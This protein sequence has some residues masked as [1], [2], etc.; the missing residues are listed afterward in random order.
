VGRYSAVSVAV[1][2]SQLQ[3]TVA[4]KVTDWLSVG[5]GAALTMGYGSDKLRVRSFSPGGDDGKLRYSDTDF[6]VQ[7][8]FGVMIEY[9]GRQPPANQGY[10]WGLG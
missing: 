1:L 10:R 6:A 5:A 7:G 4:Y 9:L 3:P 8:N 2:A